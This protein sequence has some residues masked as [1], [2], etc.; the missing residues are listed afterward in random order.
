MYVPIF[1]VVGTKTENWVGCA[2]AQPSRSAVNNP[3]ANLA[4]LESQYVQRNHALSN[5]AEV[6]MMLLRHGDV[7]EFGQAG[8]TLLVHDE[9]HV[10]AWKHD[11]GVG[12]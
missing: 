3:Q 2:T 7:D 1:R 4:A 9:K 12:G 10:P 5:H 11:S 8:G 6:D